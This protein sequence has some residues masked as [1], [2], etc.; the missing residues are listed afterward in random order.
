MD[1][2]EHTDVFCLRVYPCM[3]VQ[4][5]KRYLYCI[6]HTCCILFSI[7]TGA[8]YPLGLHMHIKSVIIHF[9]QS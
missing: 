3:V 7:L 4:E 6:I 5:R 8:K 2:C 1:Y 9:K